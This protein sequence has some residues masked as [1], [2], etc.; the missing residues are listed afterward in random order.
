MAFDLIIQDYSKAFDVIIE[1]CTLP[2][3]VIPRIIQVFGQCTYV[4][5]EN[6]RILSVYS[7]GAY[8]H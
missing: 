7:L 3:S 5:W 1:Q 6:P 8:H 4:H 2:K